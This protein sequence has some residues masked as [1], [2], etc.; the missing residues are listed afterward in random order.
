MSENDR[1]LLKQAEKLKPSEWSLVEKLIPLADSQETI[2][3]LQGIMS[4]LYHQEEFYA[5]LL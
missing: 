2:K 4:S 3:S 5:G 1:K